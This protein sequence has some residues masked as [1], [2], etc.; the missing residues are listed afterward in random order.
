M[1]VDLTLVDVTDALL[2]RQRVHLHLSLSF[3]RYFLPIFS[4]FY[5]IRRR[6]LSVRSERCFERYEC[7][8]NSGT[9]YY[10]K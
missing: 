7:R 8:G 10:L 1:H 2:F 6:V 4:F 3:S 5:V 9:N